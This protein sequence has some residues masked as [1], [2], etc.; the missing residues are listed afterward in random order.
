VQH[1]RRFGWDAT[2]DHLLTAYTG[3]MTG[4]AARETYTPAR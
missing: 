4:A 2:V 1:A 3:A